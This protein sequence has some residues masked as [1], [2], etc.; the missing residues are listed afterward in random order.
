MP[1][2]I[3]TYAF[4]EKF[5]CLGDKCEDTCCKGWGMQL[6]PVRK[7]LYEKEAPELMD[8]VTSGE[9]E[10]IM[11]RDPETDYCVKFDD[12]WCSIH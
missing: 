10:L 9:A 2:N 12:G 5:Q 11:K 3:K 4:V 1:H 7:K 8:A 6:D